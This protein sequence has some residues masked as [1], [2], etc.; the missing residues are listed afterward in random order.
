MAISVQNAAQRS[1]GAA[2]GPRFPTKTHRA[3]WE[4][5]PSAFHGQRK[6]YHPESTC[7]LCRLQSF[8]QISTFV[9][10]CSRPNE[11]LQST[12]GKWNPGGP[13]YM[14]DLRSSTA[15][16]AGAG[17][18]GATRRV[19]RQAPGTRSQENP[20]RPPPR[21]GSFK[22]RHEGKRRPCSVVGNLGAN[23]PAVGLPWQGLM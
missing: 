7:V 16:G 11:G 19:S 15:E 18:I 14:P 4:G 12:F 22:T 8:G 2:A 10:L 20:Q 9:H 1:H 23:P 5:K 3:G 13:C 21:N 6:K 17:R